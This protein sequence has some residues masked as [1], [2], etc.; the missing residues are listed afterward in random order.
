MSIKSNNFNVDK[1][2]NMT[3]SNG[4]FN[5]GIIELKGGTINNPNF[6]IKSN[7]NS[8]EE[9]F[10]TPTDVSIGTGEKY[11]RLTTDG[12]P[13]FSI[14]GENTSLS[15]LD[16]LNRLNI[17]INDVYIVQGIVHANN[18]LYDSMENKKKNIN[19]F[20]ENALEIL[21][22]IDIYE[23]N[24]KHEDNNEKKHIGFIIGD[25]YKYTKKVTGKDNTGV[26]N[27]SYTSLCVKAIQEQQEIIENQNNLIQDLIKRVENL[28]KGEQNGT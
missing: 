3:C 8:E 25:K 7:T 2:G 21:R 17:H 28:E 24:F 13:M 15:Y 5:G 9:A 14:Q 19:I 10:V 20:K 23:Y 1:N 27:Y 4:T 12:I 6:R 26:D 11:I 18:F 22:N 16:N